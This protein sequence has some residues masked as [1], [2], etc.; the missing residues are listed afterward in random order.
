MQAD[1]DAL[2]IS[3]G[4]LRKLTGLDSLRYH[5]YIYYVI[6]LELLQL[7]KHQRKGELNSAIQA[8][9]DREIS[10]LIETL[11]NLV[12]LITESIGFDQS[13]IQ[14]RKS[15]LIN[16]LGDVKNHNKLINQLDIMD[17]LKSVGNQVNLEDRAKIIEALTITRDNLVKS[18]KTEKILRENPGFRP[19]SFAV[20]L[21]S[22]RSL[23]MSEQSNEYGQLLNQALQIGISIQDEIEDGLLN[24]K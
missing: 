22:L 11:M 3:K 24:I 21:T 13:L 4:E 2:G 1:L 19:E 20:D 15:S 16:L 17:Q 10:W 12:I 23:Q 18:L 6:V 14:K 5:Y 9:G 8:F 7:P